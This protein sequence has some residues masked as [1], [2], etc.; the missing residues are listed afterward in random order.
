MFEPILTTLARLEFLGE[1]AAVGGC[2]RDVLLGL[3]PHDID[4]ATPMHPGEVIR[5]ADAAGVRALPTGLAHGTVT[6]LLGEPVEVTTYRRDVSTDGRY[7]T[8]RFADTLG[9]DLA[10]RD[11]TINALAIDPTGQLIDPFGGADDLSARRLKA[12]GN[13]DERFAEDYLRVVRGLRFSARFGLE[14]EGATERA[15]FRAAPGVRAHVSVERVVGEITK[16]FFHDGAGQFIRELYRCGVLQ[17]FIREFSSFHELAQHPEYHPEGNV[18]EHTAQVVDHAPA[19]YR[20]HALLHDIGKG[21]TAERSPHGP[22]YSFI[23]H[24]QVGAELIPGIAA[25]LKLPRVLT[26][27]IEATTRLHMQPLQLWRN[28]PETSTRAVRRLQSAAGVH[29]KALAA[30]CRADRMGR[31]GPTD[32]FLDTLFT[33]LATAEITPVLKGRHL[34]AA[35]WDPGPRFKMA[36]AKAFAYQLETGCT[37]VATLLR[38]ATAEWLKERT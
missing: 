1:R 3:T 18:L 33:P 36:L 26:A 23:R 12:V 4:V 16:A 17:A 24:E 7:A 38:V 11:F 31:S 28:S 34:I 13:P 27:S 10:R 14:L 5:R 32:R 21:A 35:G 22:W 2:V 37:D 6:L 30:V 25:R 8:V 20:W 15:L 19:A 29:L 9:E